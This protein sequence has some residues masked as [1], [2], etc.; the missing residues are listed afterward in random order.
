MS[1]SENNLI[2]NSITTSAWIK[3]QQT[4]NSALKYK[5]SGDMIHRIRSEQI[6]LEYRLSVL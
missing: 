3:K 4:G 2:Y 6:N 5:G 1:D